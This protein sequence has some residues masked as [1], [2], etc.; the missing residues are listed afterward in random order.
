VGAPAVMTAA[1]PTP[2]LD[3]TPIT[4]LAPFGQ[5]V[6]TTTTAT[7]DAS[8][9]G[10][11]LRGVLRSNRVAA[12]AALISVG[13]APAKPFM[14]GET[15]AGGLMVETVDIDSVV[16][17]AAGRRERL[18]FPVKASPVAASADTSGVA[19]IRASIPAAV[20][21]LPQ[22]PGRATNSA[23]DAGAAV[24]RYRDRIAAGPQTLIGALGATATP[25]GYRI[26]PNPSPDM[27]TAGL[28]PGDIIQKINGS[29]VG[30]AE[31]D[32]HLFEQ[33][34][35][36]GQARV[37]LVRDGRQITMSFPLR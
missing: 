9:L 35:G 25:Q 13:G 5:A 28:L 29:P 10:L 34:V 31:R 11:Q 7:G 16:L 21:G 17:A 1:A 19:A 23:S 37:E 14:V 3:L 6:S 36:S 22:S 18:G 20:A 24:E 8:S 33:A 2:P 15:V 27:R 32:R 12:S 4:T 30:D 26:G